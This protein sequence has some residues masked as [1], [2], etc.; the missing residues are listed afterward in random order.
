MYMQF[1]GST[2][3]NVRRCPNFTKFKFFSA[4][5]AIFKFICY[6]DIIGIY[7]GEKNE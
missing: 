2:A 5:V 6:N 1:Q 3:K 4:N 7:G